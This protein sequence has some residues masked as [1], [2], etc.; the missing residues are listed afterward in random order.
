MGLIA[1]IKELFSAE[2]YIQR[3]M[4]AMDKEYSRYA[5]LSGEELLALPDDEL[6]SAVLYRINARHRESGGKTQP[7]LYERFED[8]APHEQALASERMPAG[9]GSRSPRRA[10]C[11]FCPGQ[12]R[13]S[14]PRPCL[15]AE[16]GQRPGGGGLQPGVCRAAVVGG[17]CRCLHPPEH[18]P[19]L[20]TPDARSP[21]ADSAPAQDNRKRAGSSRSTARFGVIWRHPPARRAWTKINAAVA[22]GRR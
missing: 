4:E 17:N 13:R 6:L 16:S 5:E 14:G 3:A 1:K 12:S 2:R 10:L 22:G 11:G 7:H 15:C 20:R 8:M 9:G 19:T 18:R 21:A